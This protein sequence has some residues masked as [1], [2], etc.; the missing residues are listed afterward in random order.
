MVL[1]LLGL[2]GGLVVFGGGG[3]G[4]TVIVHGGSFGRF[5]GSQTL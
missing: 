5:S 2:G 3:G 4:V 1:Q